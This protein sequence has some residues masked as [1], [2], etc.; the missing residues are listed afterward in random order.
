MFRHSIVLVAFRCCYVFSAIQDEVLV[1]EKYP[2]V[3]SASAPKE[4]GLNE[5]AP[6]TDVLP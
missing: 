3:L 5:T 4:V 1:G 2:V 6:L